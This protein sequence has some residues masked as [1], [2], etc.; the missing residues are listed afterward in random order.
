MTYRRGERHG[1]HLVWYENGQLQ[2]DVCYKSGKRDGRHAVYYEGGQVLLHDGPEPW[3]ITAEQGY[4]TVWPS[5]TLHEI[6]P[7][8]SGERWAMVAWCLGPSFC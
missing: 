1:P 6:T 4:V 2:V 3:P 8:T 7:V 5:W